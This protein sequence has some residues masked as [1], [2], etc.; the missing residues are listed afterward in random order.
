MKARDNPFSTSRVLRMRYRLEAGEWD[1]LLDRL[2]GLQFRA[3]LVGP[4]GSGK[5][6]LLEDLQPRLETMGFR[7]HWLRLREDHRALPSDFLSEVLPG[8]GRSDILLFDGAEQLPGWNWAWFK[9]QARRA[10]GLVITTHQPGRLP[11]LRACATD[12]DLLATLVRELTGPEAEVWEKEAAKLFHPHQGNVR[13]VLR[14]LYDQWAALPG[15]T[16]RGRCAARAFVEQ[17]RASR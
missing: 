12:P 2:A 15:P 8:L 11:L 16:E 13:D 6:T 17:P 10:G 1:S 9:W 3:A 4:H 14:K 5:T 7:V